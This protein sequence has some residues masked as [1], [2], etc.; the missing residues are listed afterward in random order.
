LKTFFEGLDALVW[1]GTQFNN[2]GSVL[3]DLQKGGNFKVGA[4]WVETFITNPANIDLFAGK[5]PNFESVVAG[6]GRE[7]DLM[8]E[9]IYYEFKSVAAASLPPDKFKIQF[10]KDLMNG[11]I[12]NLSQI[13]WIFDGRKLN[14]VVLPKVDFLNQLRALPDDDQLRI[15]NKWRNELSLGLNPSFNDFINAL[16]NNFDLIFLI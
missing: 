5:I 7:I 1:R 4:Q 9:G 2:L 10:Y 6:L 15:L 3:A 12:T 16:D 13:R 14:G 11:N 8:V